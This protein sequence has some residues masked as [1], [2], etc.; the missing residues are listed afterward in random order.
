MRHQPWARHDDPRRHAAG[1]RV[2]RRQVGALRGALPGLRAARPHRAAFQAAEHVEQCRGHPRRGRDRAS[3]GAAG[4]SLR[5][6]AEPSHEPGAA[7]TRIRARQSGRRAGPR[8]RAGEGGGLCADEGGAD[9]G[10]AGELRGPLRRGRSRNR[11]GCGLGVGGEPAARRYRQYGF[12]G[13]GGPT[14]PPRRRY[15]PGRRDRERR[16]HACAVAGR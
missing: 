1:D 13:G 9:A 6:R 10:G 11:G 7:E 5:G 15:R 2:E 3:A 4:T 8:R 12:R 16:G 14:R